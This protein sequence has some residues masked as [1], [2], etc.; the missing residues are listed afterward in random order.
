MRNKKVI[1]TEKQ[2]SISSLS[3]NPFD[4]VEL[5]NEK[6]REVI[7][8]VGAKAIATNIP[9]FNK[10]FSVIERV[11]QEVKEEKLKILLNQFQ[12]HFDS[13]DQAWNQLRLLFASRSGLILFQK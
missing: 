13:M 6:I 10:L 5:S 2:T 8:S 11:S 9:I 4:R 7:T 1:I 12:S 3:S